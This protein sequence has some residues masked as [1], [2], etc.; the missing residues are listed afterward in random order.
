MVGYYEPE[1]VA[2]L[3][4]AIHRQYGCPAARKRQTVAAAGFLEQYGWQRQGQELVT[5]Y[6][7][8]TEN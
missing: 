5:L 8:L 4:D 3:A 1:D 2:S 6:N 7:G